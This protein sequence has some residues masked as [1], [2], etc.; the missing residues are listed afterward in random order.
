[1]ENSSKFKKNS[2]KVLF[3]FLLFKDHDVLNQSVIIVE[4]SFVISTLVDKL[5]V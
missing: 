1:M 3:Y 5:E 2:T 4:F